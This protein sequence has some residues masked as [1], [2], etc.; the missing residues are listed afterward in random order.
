MLPSEGYSAPTKFSISIRPGNGVAATGGTRVTANSAWLKRE[1]NR[2]AIGAL[3]HE[4]VHVVQQYRQNRRA[5]P[6]ATR[7][8]GW[9]TEAIPDYIRWFK[10]EPQSHGADLTWMR[11][12]R[13]FTPRYNGSYRVSANFL[14]W[15]SDKYDKDIVK[16]LNAAIRSGNYS[17]G[18]WKE[19]T[20][21]SME[22]LGDEWKKIVEEKLSAGTGGD[23]K[24]K[25]ATGDEKSAGAK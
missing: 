16:R 8:P 2:E 12:M 24:A 19:H 5:N 25:V 6:N 18:L 20:G 14:D 10:Y 23:S 15:V 13:N 7:A 21:H 22:E 3:L 4:E 11:S 17:E 1:L 9:L